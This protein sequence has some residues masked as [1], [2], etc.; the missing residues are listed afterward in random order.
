MNVNCCGFN[1]WLWCWL[2]L[3][4]V[5]LWHKSQFWES[6]DRLTP[7]N[8]WYQLN[9]NNM[10]CF[11]L[12]H[13]H[14]QMQPKP[15]LSRKWFK[16]HSNFVFIVL[17]SFTKT[18]KTKFWITV[19]LFQIKNTNISL[20]R[21][22]LFHMSSIIYFI[23]IIRYTVSMKL[24]SHHHFFIKLTITINGIEARSENKTNLNRQTNKLIARTYTFL[25]LFQCSA[26]FSYEFFKMWCRECV[27]NNRTATL[28]EFNGKNP[29]FD[30]QFYF[31]FEIVLMN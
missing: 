9:N 21:F 23:S 20:D 8:Q 3:L 22:R 24:K 11:K 7:T 17:C 28:T 2:D 6:I 1:D 15:K 18:A 10:D 31:R 13:L 19:L 26:F 14:D 25:T 16:F 29:D 27:K 4:N 5:C 12:N 30:K